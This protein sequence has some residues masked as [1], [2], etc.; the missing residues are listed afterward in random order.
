MVYHTDVKLLLGPCHSFKSLPQAWKQNIFI[1]IDAFPLNTCLRYGKTLF[2]CDTCAFIHLETVTLKYWDQIKTKIAGWGPIIINILLVEKSLPQA[3]KQ[4]IFIKIDVF[5]LNT[6]LRYGKTV[7][8]WY[9]C[10]FIHLEPYI[11]RLV[12]LSGA[13]SKGKSLTAPSP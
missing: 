11:I 2:V 6:C 5:P 7:C 10:A 13:A 12:L 3:W 9:T 4:N 1:N 8:V